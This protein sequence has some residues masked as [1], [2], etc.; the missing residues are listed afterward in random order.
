MGTWKLVSCG[1]VDDSLKELGAVFATRK[2]AG[3]AKPDIILRCN[4][5]L[6][7]IRAEST[8]R[9]RRLASSWEKSLMK[10]Q[11]MIGKV[12]SLAT[13]RDGSLNQA[14]KWDGWETD[15]TKRKRAYGKL[16]V[17]C[18][19]NNVVSTRAYEKAQRLLPPDEK[20]LEAEDK[21]QFTEQEPSESSCFQEP[22]GQ[23]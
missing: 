7:T 12:K 2:M 9:T 13:L 6:V 18:T 3:V 8:S 19:V 14:Q 21:A 15:P 23:L 11:P 17:E 5:D 20:D 10:Q 4:G 16:I 1:N 22:T